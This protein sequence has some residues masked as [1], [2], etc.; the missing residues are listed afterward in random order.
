MAHPMRVSARS[1][2][3]RAYPEIGIAYLGHHRP[4]I[5][6]LDR[7]LPPPTATW[8]AAKCYCCVAGFSR[9]SE[10]ALFGCSIQYRF[11]CGGYSTRVGLLMESGASASGW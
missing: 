6:A 4:A 1:Q 8:F 9:V 11:C 10:V 7:P 3:D 2:N 5:H